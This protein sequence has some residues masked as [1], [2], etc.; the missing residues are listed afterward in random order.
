MST[1]SGRS[2]RSERTLRV[3]VAGLGMAGSAMVRAMQQY[4]LVSMVAAAD[5]QPE[6]RGRFAEDFGAR[7]HA[8]VDVL[9]AD[10]DVEVIYIATPHQFHKEHALAAVQAGKH[11]IVEKPLALTLDDCDA[12]ISAVESSR[13]HLIVGHTE[14]YA[15]AMRTMREIIAAG[16][17]GRLAMINAWNFN[18]FLYRPRRPEELDTSLGGGILF[19]QTPHQV[20]VIRLLGG[21]LLRSVR[22]YTGVL[23]AERPTEGA[24]LAFMEFEDGAAASIVYSGYDHFDT[25]EL[26]TWLAEDERRPPEA[27]GQT[28]RALRSVRTPQEEAALRVSRYAYGQGGGWAPVH[29]QPHF[30]LTVATCERGDLRPWA[31]AVAVYDEDGRHQV[32]VRRG[33]GVPGR[34]EVLD[35]MYDAIVL[36]KPLVHTARWAKATLEVALAMLQSSRERREVELRYQVPTPAGV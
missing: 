15:P 32:P 33:R 20:D 26:H 2:E 13:M 17:L 11:V 31:D 5:T 19:N 12:I 8:T 29:H 34:G 7:P 1:I 14:S 36:G 9:L 23:D 16:S 10:P 30:G 27:Y 3:G 35:E 25:R 6:L 28:H 22:A 4:P 24:C 21:G 18:D